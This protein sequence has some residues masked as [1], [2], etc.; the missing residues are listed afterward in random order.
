MARYIR[1]ED[2]HSAALRLSL[3]VY[4]EYWT[5]CADE[6]CI[7]NSRR[8]IAHTHDRLVVQP[9]I[10]LFSL[11]V[12]RL[13]KYVLL[14][15]GRIHGLKSGGSKSWRA[16]WTRRREREGWSVR[17]GL[18]PHWGEVA[19]PPPQNSFLDFWA[20][21]GK[22]WCILGANFIAVELSVLHA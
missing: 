6:Q 16:R 21:N 20:Q 4:T 1:A 19:M 3:Q 14:Y 13:R 12:F 9:S 8:R 2:W 5:H 15:Q 17:R 10:H 18:C 11:A 22:F 7:Q